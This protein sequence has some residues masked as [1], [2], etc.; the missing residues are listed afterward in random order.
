MNRM[1]R[2]LA[3]FCGEHVLDEKLFLVPTYSAG[4]QIGQSLARTAGSWVNLRFLTFPA[5]A[6]EISAADLEAEGRSELTETEALAL[7]DGLFRELKAGN[8]LRYFH[9]LEPVPGVVEALHEAVQSLRS[10]GLKAGDLRAASFRVGSKGE[11]LNLILRLYGELLEKRKVL[12][13]PGLL[14]FALDRLSRKRKAP[15][16]GAWVLCLRDRRIGRLEKELVRAVA[17]GKPVLVPGD[18]VFGLDRPDLAWEDDAAS[19]EP[20]PSPASDAE[21]L[22]WLFSPRSAPEPFEDGTLSL[23]RAVGPA[24]EC[25]EVLRRILAGKI[26][27]DDVEVIHPPG[28]VHTAV[29]HLLAEKER[30]PATF[31]EG[32]PIAFTTVGRAF[33]GLADWIANGFLVRDLCDLVRAG[34][35]VF[36]W[37]GEDAPP[38]PEAVCRHLMGAGIV[39]GRERYLD[40]LEA[41]RGSHESSLSREG[42]GEDDEKTASL[43][44]SIS[45]IDRLAGAVRNLLAV[46]SG[47][48]SNGERAL[49]DSARL[50][51]GLVRILGSSVPAKSELDGIALEAVRSRLREAGA[52]AGE[53]SSSGPPSVAESLDRLRTLVLSLSVGASA[54]LPGHLHVSGFNSGGFS[55]RP[56]TF[57]VGLG[58]TGISARGLQDPIL[59]DGERTKVSRELPTST[60]RLRQDLHSLAVLLS[61]LRGRVVLSYSSYDILEERAAFPSSLILQAHRLIRGD[62]GLDYSDLD[63][64]L[65]EAAGFLPPDASGILD[66]RDWWFLRLGRGGRFS[67]GLDAVRDNF[68]ELRDGLAAVEARNGEKWTAY[69]GIVRIDPDRHDPVANHGIV[70]SASRLEQLAKCPYGY[71]LRYV[72]KIEPPESLEFDPSRWLDP[73]QRGLLVH[74]VLCDFM[75]EVRERREAVDPGRHRSLMEETADRVVDSW[76]RSIPPPSEAIFARERK[77]VRETLEVFLVAESRREEKVEP[78]EFEKRFAGVEI[79]IGRGRTFLLRGV[80]DRIDRVGPGAY[81]IVDYK[82]G[83]PVPYE[84]LVAFGGGRIIQHALYAVAA[85]DLLRR[86]AKDRRARVTESGYSFPTRRGEGRE[87]M[88]R[89]FDRESLRRLLADMLDLVARGYFLAGPRAEC[90]RCD[91]SS[92]C[93]GAEGRRDKSET[94]RDVF[95]VYER[96]KR[97]E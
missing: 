29:F 9:R 42:P 38:S 10:A 41:L 59:L 57:L 97:Y 74:E 85:E 65:P 94:D 84:R 27:F 79:P 72:L 2:F 91:L 31:A 90:E 83:S 26:L 1:I 16:D 5:L 28:E 66:E 53:P 21:R 73:K 39:R 92:V 45:E 47:M 11:D 23:F 86:E 68:P 60:D 87:I 78:L 17:G 76:K 71:F 58:E 40:R 95:D 32:I 67:D 24:N 56:V 6:H 36:P 19:R 61:S 51:E 96:L 77:D 70:L 52:G 88:V 18:P 3:E 34:D 69:E 20:R 13:R 30:I 8:K 49:M 80:I 33:S 50:G 35:F 7:V 22:P 4:H 37:G 89:D 12:D 25:R 43:R 46:F 15:G 44:R 55:G 48:D 81:R 75:S 82:T 54:P 63:S 64:D 93:G 62:P 14:S